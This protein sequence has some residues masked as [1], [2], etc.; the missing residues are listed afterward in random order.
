MK[1]LYIK[2]YLKNLCELWNVKNG[3]QK[4]RAQGY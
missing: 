1:L 3:F 4:D 2:F